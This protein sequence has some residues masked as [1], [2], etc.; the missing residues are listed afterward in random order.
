MQ[1]GMVGLGRMGASMVRRLQGKGLQCI[2]Y[3]P[4]PVAV[5]EARRQG[6]KDVESLQEL[7][8]KMTHPRTIWIM[9]PASAV[10]R[11]LRGAVPAPAGRLSTYAPR[12]SPSAPA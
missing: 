2:A 9:V 7:V 8:S 4:R 11:V 6:A 10:E 5:A 12:R 1:L 3:D